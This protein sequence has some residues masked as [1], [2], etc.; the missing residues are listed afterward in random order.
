[1]SLSTEAPARIRD[2]VQLHKV[3]WET[4][5]HKLPSPSGSR[6]VGFEVLLIGTAEQTDAPISPGDERSHQ[7]YYDLRQIA[8]FVIAEDEQV[9]CEIEPFDPFVALS[10]RRKFRQDI[11]LTIEIG[12]REHFDNLIVDA[13]V[14][15]LRRIE[16]ALRDL[17][18]RPGSW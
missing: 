14:R 18:A 1:M 3:C 10:P 7:V 13:E 5:P 6:I 16:Q 12:D 8:Q 4:Y 15:S 11:V 17:G 9:R 2:L